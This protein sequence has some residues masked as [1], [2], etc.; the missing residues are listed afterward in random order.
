ML[1]IKC[2]KC[3]TSINIPGAIILSPPDWRNSVIKIH[4]CIKC[5]DLIFE[6][7]NGRK[8]IEP[9]RRRK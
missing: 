6:W 7:L 1:D 4:L 3:N 5:Y 2:D 8:V 9:E